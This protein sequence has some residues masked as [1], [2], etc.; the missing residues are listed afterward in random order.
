MVPPPTG[1]D[2]EAVIPARGYRWVSSRQLRARFAQSDDGG[3]PRTWLARWFLIENVDTEE[4]WSDRV[5]VNPD[6]DPVLFRRLADLD[7]ADRDALLAFAN[8]NGPLGLR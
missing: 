2:F 8:E 4:D 6:R 5:R 3:P 7:A 1:F